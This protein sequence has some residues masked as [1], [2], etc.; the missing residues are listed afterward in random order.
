M[1][2]RR[3]RPPRA[4]SDDPDD[5]ACLVYHAAC[6][7]EMVARHTAQSADHVTEC[8]MRVVGHLCEMYRED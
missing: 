1:E 2:G 3:I 5:G 7:G 8:V 4:F 6:V